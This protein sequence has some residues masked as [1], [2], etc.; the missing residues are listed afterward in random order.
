MVFSV[1]VVALVVFAIYHPFFP[2]SNSSSPPAVADCTSG[3][4]LWQPNGDVINVT[5]LGLITYSVPFTVSVSGTISGTLIDTQA[6]IWMYVF[7]GVQYH[8]FITAQTVS[9]YLTESQVIN[10]WAGESLTATVGVVANN[11]TTGSPYYLVLWFTEYHGYS[12]ANFEA[13][14]PFTFTPGYCANSTV[15]T[16]SADQ[17]PPV[18]YTAN[19]CA[20]EP[21]RPQA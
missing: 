13:V 20:Q 5:S 17:Q 18:V 14:Q 2:S 21:V 8:Y 12:T 4:I 16:Y 10:G 3:C 15:S 9:G 1:F 11:A 19:T 7:N 6:D